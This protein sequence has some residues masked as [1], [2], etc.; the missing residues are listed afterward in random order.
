MQ[1]HPRYDVQQQLAVGDFATVYRAQDKELNRLVAI[2][3]IHPQ[4]LADQHQLERYWQEAQ[5]LASLQ[6]PNI[7]TIYDIVRERGWL[8]LELMQANLSAASQGQPMDLDFLRVTLVCCLRGLQFL[9]NNGIVHGD[10]KPTNLLLDK[11]NHVKLGDFGLAQRVTNDQGSLLKGTTKY[12]APERVSDQFGPVGP[13]SDLYSLGFS[14]Y[15]L[16]CGAAHFDTLFPGLGAFGRDQQIA[17]MMWQSA[18]DRRLPEI[19]RVLEGVPPDLARVIEKLCQKN[20]AD[21][22]QTGEQAINDLKVGMGI[23]PP[24]PDGPT[25]EELAAEE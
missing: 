10:V 3:Q 25:E 2:K 4:Y 1:P 8:V 11:N 12:M 17:W 23:T 21:R 13:A 20:P 16:M 19:A 15:E 7:M 18:P 9:H 22:Y 5:L 24:P 14:L 6:H